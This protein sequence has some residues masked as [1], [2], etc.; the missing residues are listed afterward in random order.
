MSC[1]ILPPLEDIDR[2]QDLVRL[3]NELRRRKSLRRLARAAW[4]FFRAG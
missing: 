2:P 3:E 4:Q 1:F